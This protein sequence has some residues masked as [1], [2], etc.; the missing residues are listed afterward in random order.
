MLFY[1]L[2]RVLPL[3]LL[4][5]PFTLRAQKASVDTLKKQYEQYDQMYGLNDL[6][7][8]GVLYINLHYNATGYPFMGENTFRRGSV[9]VKNENF[10]P[11]ELKYDIVNQQL[12]LKVINSFGGESH[13]ILRRN[14]I[15]QFT[16]EGGYLFE[17][18]DNDQLHPSFYQVIGEKGFRWLIKYTKFLEIPQGS[19]ANHRAYTK[20]Y[21]K[22]YFE[23]DGKV[24]DIRNRRAIKK[25]FPDKKKELKK[26]FRAH[27]KSFSAIS[28]EDFN[29]LL[30]I[31]KDA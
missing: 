16:L 8:N 6:L 29:N 22:Y 10:S 28:N 11:V 9:T 1:S 20:A 26:Y 24:F 3:L 4:C 18:I 14:F 25:L 12:V 17:W 5:L 15:H 21:R 31:L 2:R 7:V 30:N 19:Q 27:R 23:R 13:I